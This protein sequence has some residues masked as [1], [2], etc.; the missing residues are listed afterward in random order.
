MV[1]KSTGV[2]FRTS[3]SCPWAKALQNKKISRK[4]IFMAR[5]LP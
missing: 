5:R 4:I 2:M 3:I 1:L